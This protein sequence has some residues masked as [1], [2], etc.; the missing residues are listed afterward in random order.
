MGETAHASALGAPAGAGALVYVAD[1]DSANGERVASAIRT[2]QGRAE[3]V[4][5]D[6]T[7]GD[8]VAFVWAL[9]RCGTE[10]E[11]AEVPDR[12]LRL[13]LGLV[14]RADRWVVTHEHHSFPHD[15]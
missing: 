1:R 7:E 8:D 10:E 9:L 12:R 15:G 13:T 2:D 3:F 4:E 6:V 11:F 5:L 14:K